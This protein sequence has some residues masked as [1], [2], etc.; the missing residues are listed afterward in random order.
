M[1]NLLIY[2]GNR[3]SESAQTLK[4]ALV[5][6]GFNVKLNRREGTPRLGRDWICLNW[7]VSGEIPVTVHL[8]EPEHVDTAIDKYEAFLAMSERGV[9]VPEFDEELSEQ[10]RGKWLARTQLRGSGGAGIVVIRP[11]D[12]VP[13]AELYVKYIPKLHEYRVHVFSGNAI[14]IQQKRKR[15]GVE[16]TPDE[17]LIRNAEN[18]WVFCVDNVAFTENTEQQ[19]K[20][21]AVAAVS[22]LGLDFG[23]VDIIVGRDDNRPYVLE[24]NTA[25]GIESPTVLAAYVQAIGSVLNGN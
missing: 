20:D 2:R 16:Q 18:G 9:P 12:P 13:P 6:A 8:N 19:V 10:R 3:V 14:A 25:P 22:A 7:G 1:S 17:A 23:A 4:A 15:E 24:V 5:E 21:A 11:N